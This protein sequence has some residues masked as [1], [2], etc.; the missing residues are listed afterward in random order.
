MTQYVR[1]PPKF[2]EF[3]VGF[4][5][6]EPFI[7]LDSLSA[8][9]K[10]LIYLIV[11]KNMTRQQ[12][13][14]QW[15]AHFNR[16]LSS[17]A[18]QNSIKRIAF[19]QYWIQSMDG[20]NLSYLNLHDTQLL[21]DEV[22]EHARLDNAYD[23]SSILEAARCFKQ[24]RN[25]LAKCALFILK[26][27]RTAEE[28]SEEIEEPSRPWVNSLLMR[29]NAKTCYPIFIDSKRFL[30]CT[31]QV[32]N[33]YFQKFGTLFASTPPELFFVCDE[34]MVDLTKHRK[35]IVPDSMKCYLQEAIENIP[36]ITGMFTNNL[37]GAKPPPFVIIK[38]LKH[39]PKELEPLVRSG[40]VWVASSANGWMDRYCFIM[41]TICFVFWLNS[42]RQGFPHLRNHRALLLLD[43]HGSRENPLALEIF[44]ACGV[45]V[46]V[47]PPHTTHILQLFDIILPSPL[48][49]ELSKLIRERLKDESN[50]ATLNHTAAV[51]Y[52]TITSLV[53]SWNR[54][55]TLANCQV[56]AQKAGLLPAGPTEPLQSKFVREL[57][58]AEQAIVDRR[59]AANINRLNINN[60][61]LNPRIDEIRTKLAAS[62]TCSFC[63]RKI[64]SFADF[65]ALSKEAFRQASPSSVMLGAVLHSSSMNLDICF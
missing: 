38:G 15:L 45:N 16:K 59:A 4:A 52:L 50:F 51:R 26:S 29:I 11:E 34:S 55:C 62:A 20:G 53:E 40:F 1:D 48:K 60:S 56:G 10:W 65:E 9:Q 54:V 39:C 8:Q 3:C 19:S 44:E 25:K 7:H 17:Q 21:A 32:I 18:L 58:D 2:E 46:V 28:V 31:P 63:R 12:V 57:S 64:S 41:Y 5:R 42:F 43:G 14:D 13:K 30:S 27:P 36:H 35:I 6:I 24:N 23:T 22:Y 49:K 47:L 33:D 37:L 61:I